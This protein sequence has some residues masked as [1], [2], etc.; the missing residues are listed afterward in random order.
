[1]AWVAPKTNWTS[2]TKNNSEDFSRQC[3]NIEHI[4]TEI[5]PSLYYHPEYNPVP[6]GDKPTYNR[7]NTLE[8][9]LSAIAGCGITL[10]GGWG[11]S[12]TWTPGE[13]NPTYQDTNRW[14]RNALLLYQMADRIKRRWPVSGTFASGQSSILPRMVI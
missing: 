12:K 3:D 4:A 1:M 7:Y 6:A 14:E 5:L 9:N 11:A 13:L 10:P 8:E 2:T